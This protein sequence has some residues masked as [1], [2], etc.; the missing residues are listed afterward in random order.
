MVWRLRDRGPVGVST[1]GNVGP[2]GVMS[3]PVY[4][5]NESTNWRGVI[6]EAASSGASI[7]A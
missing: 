1:S 2:G 6:T 5:S 7:R 3:E 4:V